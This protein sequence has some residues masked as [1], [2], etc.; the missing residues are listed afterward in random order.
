MLVVL[1]LELVIRGLLGK[2]RKHVWY[3]SQFSQSLF[4][5]I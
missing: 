1:A 5:L 4:H 3:T 2:M